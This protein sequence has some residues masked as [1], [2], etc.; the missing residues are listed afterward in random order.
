MVA[1]SG[2]ACRQP[3][4]RLITVC[5]H[6]LRRRGSSHQHT[7]LVTF[8]PLGSCWTDH[9]GMT[10]A[11]SPPRWLRTAHTSPRR[12]L[13]SLWAWMVQWAGTGQ[14][15]RLTAAGQNHQALMPYISAS[16]AHSCCRLPRAASSSFSRAFKRK[17]RRTSAYR[18]NMGRCAPSQDQLMAG[19][20]WQ[21][22][23]AG[24]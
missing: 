24:G 9:T 14:T 18:F 2:T 1:R 5:W 23:T 6:Y 7:S 13:T 8:Y 21:P 11:A 19:I 12:Y 20:S 15:P 4:Q 22:G 16:G 17:T 3:G 10:L